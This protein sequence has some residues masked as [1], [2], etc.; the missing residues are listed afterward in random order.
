VLAL[1]R[2]KQV[3]F[4]EFEASLVYTESTQRNPVSIIIIITPAHILPSIHYVLVLFA[5]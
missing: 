1:G 3:D 2:Q 4:C 5:L